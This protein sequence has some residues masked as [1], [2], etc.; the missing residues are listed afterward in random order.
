MCQVKLRA[1]AYIK[2]RYVSS[3]TGSLFY[4]F[5]RKERARRKQIQSERPAPLPVPPAY[6]ADIYTVPNGPRSAL[7][8][9]LSSF[10][11]D[12]S[13]QQDYQPRASVD[14]ARY[15]ALP[16]Y[17]P[18]KYQPIRPTSTASADLLT[19]YAHPN[20]PSGRSSRLSAAHYNDVRQSVYQPSKVDQYS[21]PMPRERLASHA[22]Q[23]SAMPSRP[24][25]T[26]RHSSRSGEG[27]ERSVSEP[28]PAA[29]LQHKGP[30]RGKPV[31]S[32]LITNFG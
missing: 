16:T 18:S 25:V 27:S 17:D 1:G 2:A 12:F 13:R 23:T 9:P 24:T 5:S 19:S 15:P 26:E 6:K 28:M 8:R 11:P 4:L 3:M 7:P 14:H 29:G 22:R 32:R 20:A 10:A 31:L 21:P 30:R